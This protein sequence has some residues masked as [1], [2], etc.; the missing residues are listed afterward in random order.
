VALLLGG[1]TAWL[2]LRQAPVPTA[3]QDADAAL[4]VWRLLT[5]GAG[6]L[7]ALGLHSRLRDLEEM[8]TRPHRQ[9]EQR[10]LIGLSVA[11]AAAFLAFASMTLNPAQITVVARSLLGWLGLSLISGRLF[12]WQLAWALPLAVSGVLTYWGGGAGNGYTWWQFTARPHNDVPSLLLSACLLAAGA[13]AYS[14]SAW[15]RKS[16]RCYHTSPASQA[17]VEQPGIAAGIASTPPQAS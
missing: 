11:C 4:P 10:Y 2:G 3:A 9:A 6:M 12:G 13:L 17:N 8:S 7:P 16:L 15:R 5:M 1:F 14:A